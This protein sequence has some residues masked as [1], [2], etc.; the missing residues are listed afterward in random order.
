MGFIL[1]YNTTNDTLNG[2]LNIEGLDFELRNNTEINTI[3]EGISHPDSNT[4][5]C[6]FSQEPTQ[7]QTTTVNNIVNAHE[8]NAPAELV[9]KNTVKNAI[10][11]GNN[12]IVEF[13]SE[14]VLL[15]ITQV[16]KTKEVADYLADLMRY[17]Q[18]GSLYEVINEVDRLIDAGLPVNLEPFITETK[19]NAFKQ[20]VVD[21]LS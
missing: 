21:Y 17:A 3:F 7:Q 10:E 20:Q 11:F 4:F 2:V 15:G 19:M 13:A 9:V 1:S 8:G 16:G 6:H 12:L 14:N 18:T 5:N